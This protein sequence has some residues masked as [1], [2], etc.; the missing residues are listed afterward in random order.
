M[1]QTLR[2]THKQLEEY[3]VKRYGA[4]AAANHPVMAIAGKESAMEKVILSQTQNLQQQKNKID[5]KP[6]LPSMPEKTSKVTSK[7]TKKQKETALKLKSDDVLKQEGALEPLTPPN[8]NTT[9]MRQR[10]LAIQSLTDATWSGTYCQGSFLEIRF[11]GAVLLSVNT[12]YS[13]THYERIK[14]R[15]AWHALIEKAVFDLIGACELR[16]P[17]DKYILRAHRVSRKLADTDSKNGYLKYPIDGLRYSGMLIDDSPK[18]FMDLI[19]S[20]S[21]GLPALILRIESVD[22]S[23]ISFSEREDWT[24]NIIKEFK[25]PE[26]ARKIKIKDKTKINY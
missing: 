23:Y 2:W 12:L 17:F 4:Q 7:T 6:T 24:Q 11:Y 1:T 13:L 15:K 20:Q 5:N 25:R 8:K 14:Y 21:I 3:M 26:V 18:Y 10:S 16:L 22:S 9:R 19:S